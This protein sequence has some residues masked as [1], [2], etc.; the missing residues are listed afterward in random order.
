MNK[1]IFVASITTLLFSSHAFA[2]GQGAIAGSASMFLSGTGTVGH[3]SSSIAVAKVNAFS[4]G[5]IA[6][7]A[8]A[9]NS[10]TSTTATAGSQ[11]MTFS[12]GRLATVVAD[13]AGDLAKAQVNIMQSGIISLDATKAANGSATTPSFSGTN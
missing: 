8:D 7:G 13:T 2:I 4:E 12:S 6:L 1:I 3:L 11:S 9:A 5:S 10:E